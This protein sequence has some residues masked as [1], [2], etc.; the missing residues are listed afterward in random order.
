MKLVPILWSVL[1]RRFDPAM[2]FFF[3]WRSKFPILIVTRKELHNFA[4]D[5]CDHSVYETAKAFEPA[6]ETPE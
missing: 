2:K 5:F 1:D 3:G 4:H 6:K